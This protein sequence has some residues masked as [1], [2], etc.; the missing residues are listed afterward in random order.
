MPRNAVS[1]IVAATVLVALLAGLD[2]RAADAPAY[3]TKAVRVLSGYPPGGPADIMGRILT[4][5]FSTAFGQPFYIEAKPGAAGN[6]AGEI[7]A[8]APPDGHTLYLAGLGNVA[9]NRE[10]YGNMSYDPA[11]AYAPI[12]IL[13][14]FPVVLEVSAKLKVDD[15]PAFIAYAKGH[16]L[17]HGSPGIGTMVHLA[18]E[19][20]RAKVGIDSTHIPY[21]GTGPFS[22]GMIQGELDW[23]FDVPNA[24]V[25]LSQGGFVKLLAISSAARHPRFPE[26]PTLVELGLADFVADTW[27]ALVA[28]AGTPAPI[29]ARLSAEVAR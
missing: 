21:R 6:L 22:S 11:T 24:A 10:L 16:K 25:T 26:L 1:T 27:F 20:F 13:A 28:P 12:S 4:D 17:S 5:H 7:L 19:L 29:I 3:P 9:V 15:Y 14:H 18:G 8:N 2:A 23:A